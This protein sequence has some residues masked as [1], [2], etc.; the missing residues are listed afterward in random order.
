LYLAFPFSKTF[1]V[2]LSE[3]VRKRDTEEEELESRDRERE[4]TVMREK[5][6]RN[7]RKD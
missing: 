6:E 3:T 7:N 1:L 2:I 5:R 4:S